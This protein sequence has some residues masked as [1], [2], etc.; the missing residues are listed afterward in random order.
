MAYEGRS[1][2]ESHSTQT[3]FCLLWL[4]D[5][6]QWLSITIC[7]LR[8]HSFTICCSNQSEE[9]LRFT[10]GRRP[11]VVAR[12]TDATLT[13]VIDTHGKHATAFCNAGFHTQDSTARQ[14][15]GLLQDGLPPHSHTRAATAAV[16]PQRQRRHLGH[17][18]VLCKSYVAM[19]PP[20]L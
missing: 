15:I 8:A 7:R 20:H 4:Y 10:W 18:S 17:A 1:D 11:D 19:R 12:L 2:A 13:Q 16:D 14:A 5:R 6:R 3:A 9:P